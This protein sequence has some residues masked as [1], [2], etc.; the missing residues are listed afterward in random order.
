MLGENVLLSNCDVVKCINCNL[1]QHHIVYKI[2][3]FDTSLAT[4]VSNV[5]LIF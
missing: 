5:F 4:I 2:Y 3:A 1:G